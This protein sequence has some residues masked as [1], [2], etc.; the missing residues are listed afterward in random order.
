MKKTFNERNGRLSVANLRWLS[1]VQ[2]EHPIVQ[3]KIFFFCT[4]RAQIDEGRSGNV[5]RRRMSC[6]WLLRVCSATQL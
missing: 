1:R 6:V 2:T 3:G 4:D 5:K